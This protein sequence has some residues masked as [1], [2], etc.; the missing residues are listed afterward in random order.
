MG[1]PLLNYYVARYIYW[2]VILLRSNNGFLIRILHW[3]TQHAM[4]NALETMELTAAQGHIMAYLAHAVQPPCPRDLEAE[5]HLTHPTVS[6]LL[7]RL[8][9]KGFLELRTDPEDRRCK[10][11]YVLEKGRQCHAV[12]HRT[13]QKNEQRMTEGFTEEEREIF[14]DLLRRAIRNMGGDPTP[15]RFKEEDSE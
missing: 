12:M 14:S 13:I 7:S 9:Q 11:I 15:R 1:K 4:D 3:C 8:E 2:E 6:G 5:F 10:R